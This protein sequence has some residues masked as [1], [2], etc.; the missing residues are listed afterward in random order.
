MVLASSTSQARVDGSRIGGIKELQPLHENV[1]SPEMSAVSLVSNS[2]SK[3][4]ALRYVPMEASYG[5]AV[6]RSA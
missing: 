3:R 2:R 1:D 5:R 4:S 6:H